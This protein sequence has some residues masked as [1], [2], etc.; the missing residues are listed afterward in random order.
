[1]DGEA[2]R[3]KDIVSI[4]RAVRVESMTPQVD[5][6]IKRLKR[7]DPNTYRLLRFVWAALPNGSSL[8]DVKQCVE[9]HPIP[10]DA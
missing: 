1:M 2:K 4:Y 10:C 9:P 7:Q 5:H 6:F 8:H 3:K